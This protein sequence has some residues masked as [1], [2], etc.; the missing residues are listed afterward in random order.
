[1]PANQPSKREKSNGFCSRV[2]TRITGRGVLSCVPPRSA[3]TG[4]AG[5]G[6]GA[7]FVCQFNGDAMRLRC[8]LIGAI[9]RD[10]LLQ[11]VL[12]MQPTEDRFRFDSTMRW[13]SV[14]SPCSRPLDGPLLIISVVGRDSGSQAHMGSA[15]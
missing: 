12:V 5:C 6:T 8:L 9:S 4:T 13:Q 14:P 3:R 1:M 11:R 2:S 15:L 7:A 10:H